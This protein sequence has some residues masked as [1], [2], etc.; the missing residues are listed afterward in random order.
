MRTRKE[1]SKSNED[2]VRGARTVPEHHDTF[3]K[4]EA[5]FPIQKEFLP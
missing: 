4:T 1:G 2:L 5:V 3:L